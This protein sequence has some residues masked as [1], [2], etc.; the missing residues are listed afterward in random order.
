MDSGCIVGTIHCRLYGL[1]SR[2]IGVGYSSDGM[3][4]AC[5]FAY[6]SVVVLGYMGLSFW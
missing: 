4:V 6:F 5:E 1:L 3:A 2:S